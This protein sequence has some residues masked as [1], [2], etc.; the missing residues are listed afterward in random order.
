[1]ARKRKSGLPKPPQSPAVTA[2]GADANGS[3]PA[4]SA[5]V[6][7]PVK[8]L[9]SRPETSP[10][11]SPP[12]ILPFSNP[13]T[14]PLD[15]LKKCPKL[16][17][18][19]ETRLPELQ[20]LS[21]D[22]GHVLIHYLHTGTYGS[23]RPRLADSASKQICELKT[24]IQ[25]YAAARTYELHGL[26]RLAEAKIDK[27][28]RGLSLPALLEVARDAYPNLTDDD[29]WFLD[30]LRSRIRP[31]LKDPKSLLNSNL[32]GQISNILSPNPILLRT[33]LELFC[34]RSAVRT[35]RA[36]SPALSSLASP[37]TSA[38]TS[39]AVSPLPATLEARSRSI[40]REEFP[41]SRRALKTTSWPSPSMSEASLSR[42]T[43]CTESANLPEVAP[44]PQFEIKPVPLPVP[45]PALALL[46]FADMGPVIVD[47]VPPPGAPIQADIEP[48]PAVESTP[49]IETEP[50]AIIKP[51]AESS[52]ETETR[53]PV[54]SEAALEVTAPAELEPEPIQPA[55][56]VEDVLPIVQR[57]RKDSGKDVDLS[58]IPKDES[59]LQL[60]RE[61]EDRSGLQSPIIPSLLR[62]ADSGFWE[63]T[64]IDNVT[65]D[66]G[67]AKEKEPAHAAALEPTIA[68]TSDLVHEPEPAT[69]SKAESGV[70]ARD[71]AAPAV[72]ALTATTGEPVEAK[73]EATRE[74]APVTESSAKDK[75]DTTPE[76]EP[77]TTSLP[78]SA[79]PKEEVDP[80]ATL[81]V[82]E[83]IPE[84]IPET[85]PAKEVPTEAKDKEVEAQP[86]TEKDPKETVEP[87]A[88]ENPEHEL[89]HE[90]NAATPDPVNVPDDAQPSGSS[91]TTTAEP[92]VEP[93]P[94]PAG[95]PA[96][97]HRAN[98]D[99]AIHPVPVAEETG[100]KSPAVL[101][102]QP[103]PE[104]QPGAKAQVEHTTPAQQLCSAHVRQRSWK[105]RFLSLR[106]PVFFARGM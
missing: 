8:E 103:A 21:E 1:M 40:I 62:E 58:P 30:Y 47:V 43:T 73:D 57:E 101:G 28:G 76:P 102:A 45:A 96:T 13:L 11:A 49:D 4:G 85:T 105:K 94:K 106:Y 33:L 16:Y 54:E 59:A 37:I 79:P 80:A 72:S 93:G 65:R 29:D 51:V 81:A 88:V 3:A 14:V 22:V 36:P 9:D 6:V 69:Q 95:E 23:L 39:R 97:L 2:E 55:K 82:P 104:Q 90:L 98:T 84:I 10:Y 99:S 50:K 42:S 44:P 75:V 71:F 68:P 24:S 60:A 31:H 26:M 15:V 66:A 19:Y 92:A 35:D 53:T 61:V 5:A 25:V 48:Q 34:E 18:A 56:T 74:T 32:L 70:N 86:E 63:A 89:A 38:A 20:A 41:P 77:A 100:N 46:P 7:A 67:P 27:H 64:D 87:K 91:K 83:T 12:C 78:E 52:V 17:E